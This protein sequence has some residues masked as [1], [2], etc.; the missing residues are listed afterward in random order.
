MKIRDLIG[1][2]FNLKELGLDGIALLYPNAE[3]T[4]D[5][6]VLQ[7][8]YKTGDDY[9]Y[10]AVQLAEEDLD[11][12]FTTY[13]EGFIIAAERREILNRAEVDAFGGT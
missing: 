2:T 4:A 13:L 9:N 11:A 10:Y 12:E 5:T 1:S 3:S 8:I 6:W 7:H